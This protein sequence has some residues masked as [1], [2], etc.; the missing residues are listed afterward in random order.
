MSNLEAKLDDLRR[1]LSS[2]NGGVFP[3]AV[4]S[5]QQISLL[6]RQKPTT[7]AEVRFGSNILLS[8]LVLS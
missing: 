4:L 1:E 3:H 8:Y 5:A 2:S 6:N 7:V